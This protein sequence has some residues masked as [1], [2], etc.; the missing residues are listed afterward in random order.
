[1]NDSDGAP[2]LRLSLVTVGDPNQLTGGYRY[3]HMMVRAASEHG[4]EIHVSSIPTV[5]WPIG[6]APSARTLHS[7]SDQADA[8]LLDSIAAALAAPWIG[9]A[10][11]P[12]VAIVHQ[13][14]GGVDHGGVRSVAQGALDRLAYRRAAGLVAVSESLVEDLCGTGVPLEQIRVV[15]P[16]CDVPVAEGPPLDLRCG[17]AAAVLCVANWTPSKG[18]VELVEAFATLPDRAATLWLVGAPGADRAYA[19]RVR[20]RISAP[21]LS[22][23]VVI[24]GA[25]P[26]DEVARMYRSAD[27]FALCSSVDVYGM[28]WTEALA[29]GL[30]VIGWRAANLPRLVE[31]GREALL[32]APGDQR[33]LGSALRAITTDPAL[34]QRLAE[35]ARR[36]A[37]T[38]PTWRH[39]AEL[40]FGALREL[41]EADRRI[42]V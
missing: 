35:G 10:R 9:R 23:R 22:R 38:L 20:R 41:L 33:A 1:M 32:P 15:P 42:R 21:D 3:Q 17:R 13:A 34:R 25:L 28:A 39:S 16:G 19:D 7:A 12:V 14:P 40:F 30:P 11:T 27:V 4:A 36:R 37:E 2:A 6:I 5:P 29:A 24:C 31:D 8:I 26:I 18:I